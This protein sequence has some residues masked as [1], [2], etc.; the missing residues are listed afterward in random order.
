[1]SCPSESQIRGEGLTRCVVFDDVS[2]DVYGCGG[3]GHCPIDSGEQ[4][5]KAIRPPE[6]E[7]R[8]LEV[9]LTHTA[10]SM[11]LCHN[12]TETQAAVTSK[13]NGKDR[14]G[15]TASR[16]P[17]QEREKEEKKRLTVGELN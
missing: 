2:D 8:H 11:N 4:G 13:A 7:R 9:R 17:R 10:I 5:E 14:K 16:I 12:N 6:P 15:K 1:M 3:L